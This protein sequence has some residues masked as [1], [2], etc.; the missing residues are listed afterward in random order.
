M[1]LALFAICLATL[2]LAGARELLREAG[3]PRGFRTRLTTWNQPALTVDAFTAVQGYVL[4]LALFSVLVFLVIHLI[5]FRFT[6]EDPR[7]FS[8][9]V[10]ERLSTPVGAGI[11]FVGV[12]ALGLHLWHAFQSLF[13]SL[14]L[15]H[16]RYSPLIKTAGWGIATLLAVLFWL[17]PTVCL[18][19]PDRWSFEDPDAAVETEHGSSD[20]G[21]EK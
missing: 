16:P 19:K 2:G 17:F 9:M 5:D 6:E 10:V 13:Q 15:H 14:G 8:Y 20:H 4:V 1:G 11:Y 21:G 3:Y 7:G 18:L 12:G